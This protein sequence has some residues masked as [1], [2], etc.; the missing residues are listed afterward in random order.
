MDRF[1]PWAWIVAILAVA[2]AL[3]QV[4]KEWAL[5]R[6]SGGRTISVLPT[7]EFDL[8]FN[9]G[10]SF[11]TGTGNGRLIGLIVIAVSSALAWMIVRERDRTRASILAVILGGA[12]GNLLDRLLRGDSF[13]TGE[14]V[15]FIDVSWYAVFN[16]AD[17]FVVCGCL[18]LVA[19]ELRRHHL[20][21]RPATR[22]A[23]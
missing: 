22:P 19:Y 9:S 3:D 7:L 5:D 20:E 12:L 14:V 13:L 4:T 6:L 11:G 1:K 15:D 21:P 23:D 10:F 8:T 18:L 2:V 17:I 16:V